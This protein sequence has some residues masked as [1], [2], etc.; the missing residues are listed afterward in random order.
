MLNDD[1]KTKGLRG[2]RFSR[3]F[4]NF[5]FDRKSL[6]FYLL[7]LLITFFPLNDQEKNYS[8][9]KDQFFAF[10]KKYNI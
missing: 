6:K 9:V 5:T 8:H 7:S 4:D 2:W 10:K 1:L 3:K